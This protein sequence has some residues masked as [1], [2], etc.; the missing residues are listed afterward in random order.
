M[1]D[2]Q[3]LRLDEMIAM[4][5]RA[6]EVVPRRIAMFLG[7]PRAQAEMDALDRI[8]A[9]I[10]ETN[11]A[12]SELYWSLVDSVHTH[13]NNQIDSHEGSTSVGQ[14]EATLRLPKSATDRDAK[15]SAFQTMYLALEN[16]W[17]AAG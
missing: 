15:Y 13:R 12:I 5:Q 8:H 11:P 3:Q 6:E 1:L 16:A 10:R 4:Y 2:I 14:A 7:Y 17:K 9:Y